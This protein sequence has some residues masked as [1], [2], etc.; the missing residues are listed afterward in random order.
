MRAPLERLRVM[1]AASSLAALSSAC[2]PSASPD[3]PPTMRTP[4]QANAGLRVFADEFEIQGAPKA[5]EY[6]FYPCWGDVERAQDDAA[7]LQG[8]TSTAGLGGYHPDAVKVSDGKLVIQ[9]SRQT[10]RYGGR[11][12]PYRSGML[13]T[14][15]SY[16]YGYFEIRAKQPAGQGLWPVFWLMPAKYD[17]R[18]IWE[19]DVAE[20]PGSASERLYMNRHWGEG[21][22]TP[23]HH[24]QLRS[25]DGDFSDGFHVFAVEWTPSALTWFIDGVQRY[26]LT[27]HVPNVPLQVLLSFNVGGP[28]GWVNSFDGTT[29]LPRSWQID[30]L[31]IDRVE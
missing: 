27:D 10:T 18:D 4:G 31:H 21:Y 8:D 13:R 30:Y 19:I 9:A 16:L 15:A 29:P 14:K 12:F 7:F 25:F 26:R 22:N 17:D 23:G 3:G 6:F 24:Q 5:D 20:L 11:D 1:L 2:A 28:R